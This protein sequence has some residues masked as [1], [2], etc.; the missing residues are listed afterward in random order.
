MSV[1]VGVLVAVLLLG[2]LLSPALHDSP[3]ERLVAGVSTV[4]LAGLGLL[5]VV[6]GAVTGDASP[7]A[8]S[9]L[10]AL[11]VVAVLGGSP[12]TAAMLWLVDRDSSDVST[13]ASAG[14]VL[15]GGAWIGRFERVAVFVVVVAGW[16]NGLAIVLAL[17][18]LGRYSELRAP[19][20]PASSAGETT[21]SEA[22]APGPPPAVAER[23]LIGTF[24]SVLW[25]AACAGA[26]L[27]LLR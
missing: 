20:P 13:V 5:A 3:A 2:A 8:R 11:F 9:I 27:T 7:L 10:V 22:D 18:G 14:D 12:V 15:R 23:F 17:K 1:T 4:A 6:G 21:G 19:P 16:P 25:A 24:A 26:Y